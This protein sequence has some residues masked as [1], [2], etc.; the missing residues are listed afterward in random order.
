MKS[1]KYLLLNLILLFA[2]S[3]AVPQVSY[4]SYVAQL[5]ELVNTDTVRKYER[6]LSGDT[7]CSIGG[8]VYTIVSRHYATAGNIKAAEYIYEKFQSYGITTWYQVINSTI[9][10]VLAKRTGTKYP[11]QYFIICGHYDDM[12]S[13]T[14]APGADDNASGVVCVLEAARILKNI[15]FPYTIVFA[16]WDEEE[17][18]LY[19]SKAYADTA[20]THGDSIIGVLNLDMIAYDGNNDGALDVHTNTAC[21]PLATEFAQTVSIYQPSLVP[22]VTTS[23]S[24]GSDHQSFLNKGYKAILSIEDN[25]EMTPYYHTVNDTYSSLNFPYFIKMLK[26]AVAGIVTWA[27]DYKISIVHTPLNSGPVTTDRTVTAVI[28][29]SM[30]L[31]TGIASPK[32]FYKINNGSFVMVSSGYS[33]LD[34]FIFTIPGQLMGTTVKYYIAAQDSSGTLI[35]TLPSGGSGINPPGSTPPSEQFEYQVINVNVVSI[36]TGSTGIGYPYYT[37][38]E[39]SRTLM[40]YRASEIIAGGGSTGNITKIG[41]EV[42]SA[43]SQTMNSF[44]IKMKNYPGSSVT[45]WIDTGWTTVYSGTYTVPGIGWQFITFQSPFLWNGTDNLLIE[46]CFDNTSW[47]SNSMITGF[48]PYTG[49]TYHRHADGSAGCSLTGSSTSLRL[50][51]ATLRDFPIKAL[52]VEVTIP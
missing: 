4:N 15:E 28:K 30:K 26:A 31:G 16:A 3:E 18:G 29:T 5:M 13:G 37:Y 7:S 27:G 36:G 38:Y 10:N 47:S 46:I 23:L 39:D 25:S 51:S 14:T 17:R 35:A 41:F 48:T 42:T 6:E 44:N 2:V 34:T 24:G 45:G 8:T 21:V 49:L 50:V 43:S 19:G 12:P 11:N 9:T 20:Y 52:T 40:L 33:N 32:L 1:L 22:Q